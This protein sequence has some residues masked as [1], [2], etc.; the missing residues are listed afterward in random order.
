MQTKEL[1][2]LVVVGLVGCIIVAGF[3]PVLNETVDPDT[4][5]TNTGLWR[6]KE[7]TQ[8]DEWTYDGT[9]WSYNGDSTG[10]AK[11]GSNALLGDDW[12]MRSNGQLR[13][14][15]G[16]G[17]LSNATVTVTVSDLVQI[18]GSGLQGSGTHDLNGYGVALDGAFIMS[19]YTNTNLY[20][21]GD[22]LL[23][24]TGATSITGTNFICHVEA[25][26]NG[27]A[28]FTIMDAYNSPTITDVVISNAKVNYTAVDGYK[29]LYRVTSITCDIACN[30][31]SGGETTA[32]T[33]TITYSSIVA[34]YQIT[35]EKAIHADANTASIL[36][37]I[38]FILIVGIVIM[39]VGVV[40]VRRY[41]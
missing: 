18:T 2:G 8:G 34:P 37:M 4:T 26:I 22:T 14:N 1:I 3:I 38:P 31:T 20:A 9:T 19:D 36:S 30:S 12:A 21:N 28:T 32:C 11:L 13:S 39:F 40:L 29:D 35:A 23:Y 24:G 7:I 16:A 33:G 6:M 5:F 25:T 41:V 10:I 17:N 15:N 27:G